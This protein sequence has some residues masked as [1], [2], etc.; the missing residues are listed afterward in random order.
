MIFPCVTFTKLLMNNLSSTQSNTF[1][2]IKSVYSWHVFTHFKNACNMVKHFVSSYPK[3]MR[4]FSLTLIRRV[5]KHILCV[6]LCGKSSL[7]YPS[8]RKFKLLI[9]NMS[10][11]ICTETYNNAIWATKTKNKQRRCAK[12]TPLVFVHF[13]YTLFFLKIC[14]TPFFSSKNLY[15]SKQKQ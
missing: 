11:K 8:K 4:G 7:F 14:F 9:F 10:W 13:V 6:C 15:A 3:L 2:T 5:F 12:N 1:R